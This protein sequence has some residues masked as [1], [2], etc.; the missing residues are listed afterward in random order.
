MENQIKKVNKNYY[1]IY[2]EPICS[3]FIDE[4]LMKKANK[5]LY[6]YQNEMGALLENNTE[7]LID[8]NWALAYPRGEQTVFQG[9]DLKPPERWRQPEF[10][11]KKVE[12]L[13]FIGEESIYNEKL[14]KKISKLLEDK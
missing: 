8:N 1:E 2:S 14:T 5:I 4:Y 3:V 13:F 7:H 10:I 12:N 6:K 9:T 11:T